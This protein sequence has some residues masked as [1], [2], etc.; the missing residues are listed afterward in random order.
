MSVSHQGAPLDPVPTVAYNGDVVVLSPELLGVAD[1]GYSHF[2]AGNVL[3]ASLP[4]VVARL[5]ELRYVAEFEE[6][7]QACAASC[8]FFDFCQGAQAGNRYF[9]HGTF[10][11]TETAYCRNTR[12]AL[13][14][15]AADEITGRK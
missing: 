5:G 15:A 1:P 8:G 7:V 3:T 2:L 13:V 4:H 9:E 14:Q 12:Q 6:G 11:A 10:A